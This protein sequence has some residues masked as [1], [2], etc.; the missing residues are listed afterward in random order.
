MNVVYHCRLQRELEACKNCPE[1]LLCQS[2]SKELEELQK[3]CY[4]K[5]M[6]QH[7]PQQRGS[8]GNNSST[9]PSVNST[10]FRISGHYN[11][12]THQYVP[13]RNVSQGMASSRPDSSTSAGTTADNWRGRETLGNDSGFQDEQDLSWVCEGDNEMSLVDEE[14]L[15]DDDDN[16][17]MNVELDKS[18]LAL[19]EDDLHTTFSDMNDPTMDKDFTEDNRN[20]RVPHSIQRNGTLTGNG[21][22]QLNSWALPWYIPGIW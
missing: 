17:D 14:W 7:F 20:F 6:R 16:D 9:I 8:A 22:F 12:Y 3:K 11:P 1:E 4:H 10:F 21:K 5:Q 19:L 18:E 13:A 15:M 2:L